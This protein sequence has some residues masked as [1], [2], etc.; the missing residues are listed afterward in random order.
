MTFVHSDLDLFLNIDL[1][2]LSTAHTTLG[3]V[4]LA[5]FW[6]NSLAPCSLISINAP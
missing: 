6:L 4:I 3:L 1:D 2:L 5:M